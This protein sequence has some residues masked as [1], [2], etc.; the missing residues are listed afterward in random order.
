MKTTPTT[1][2]YECIIKANMSSNQS[3]LHMFNPPL[4]A[5]SETSLILNVQVLYSQKLGF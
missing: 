5:A 3:H 1:L 2:T 4:L